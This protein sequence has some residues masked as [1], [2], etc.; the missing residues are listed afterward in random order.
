MEINLWT[1]TVVGEVRT[2]RA[3]HIKKCTQNKQLTVKKK[4]VVDQNQLITEK[5]KSAKV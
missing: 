3:K 5:K 4:T 2:D 1:K